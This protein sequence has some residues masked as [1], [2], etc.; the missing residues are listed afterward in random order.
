MQSNYFKP[1]SY[2]LMGLSILF[3]FHFHLM[4]SLIGGMAVYLIVNSLH[5]WVGTKVH[6]KFAHNVTLLAMVLFTVAILTGIGVGIYSGIHV[7]KTNF[8]NLSDD[9][10]KI[11]QQLKNY[12][13]SSLVAYIPED[14]IQLKEH[15]TE[16]LKNNVPN[17]LTITIAS[18]KGLLHVIIGMLIGS[19]IVFSLLKENGEKE[20]APFAKELINRISLFTEV[21][22]KVIFAQVKISFINTVLTA[23]Y[24]LVALPIF[25]IH[26]PYATTLVLLTFL[27]G[28]LPVIGN[29]MSNAFIV[30]LSLMVSFDV[31]IASLSFL[32]IVHKLEYYVNAKIVGEQI[33]TSIWE[34]LIVMLILESAFGVLGAVLGPVLY[35][36]IKEE[37][38]KNK[39]V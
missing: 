37:L 34:M 33:K 26:I 2:V 30:L 25:G 7:G 3:L 16:I 24:L 39:L 18:A 10:L 5:S 22:Q 1:V 12:L 17:M 4:T 20:Q 19:I 23:I 8:V 35:G 28:L 6:S 32:V 14:V 11:L 38:Q 9:A 13:P 21:F 31:A 36:Y 27:F 29:L 15:A